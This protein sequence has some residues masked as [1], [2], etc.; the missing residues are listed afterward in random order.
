MWLDFGLIEVKGQGHMVTLMSVLLVVGVE[1][2]DVRLK[3]SV[4]A[5]YTLNILLLLVRWSSN[6]HIYQQFGSRLVE[7][8]E[9]GMIV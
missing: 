3:K 7:I 5:G 6:V 1:E 4:C 8:A 9:K 2:R